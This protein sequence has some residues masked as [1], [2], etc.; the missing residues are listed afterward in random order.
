MTVTA[1]VLSPCEY[2][3]NSIRLRII[4]FGPLLHLFASYC[5]SLQMGKMPWQMAAVRLQP[6][7]KYLS[8]ARAP[9]EAWMMYD[10]SMKSAGR[11]C[12]LECP[13]MIY[14]DAFLVKGSSYKFVIL[15][16][17]P[18]PIGRKTPFT[19]TSSAV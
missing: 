10:D 1:L 9:A 7:T 12:S 13:A 8:P 15:S 17:Y 4:A 5:M 18:L 16:L 19:S 14:K 3:V 2:K 11:D 6:A